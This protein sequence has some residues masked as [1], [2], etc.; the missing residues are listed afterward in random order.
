VVVLVVVVVVAL[1]SGIMVVMV[2]REMYHRVIHQFSDNVL[3]VK[4]LVLRKMSE[5]FYA[6]SCESRDV[7]GHRTKYELL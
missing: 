2:C 5:H 4:Q 7:M 3:D 6:S 1:G